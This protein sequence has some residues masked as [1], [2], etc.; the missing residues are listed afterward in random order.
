MEKTISISDELYQCFKIAAESSGLDENA[1]LND[2]IS[3]Y[4]LSALSNVFKGSTACR[5]NRSEKKVEVKES[6]NRSEDTLKKENDTPKN[7]SP[8]DVQQKLFVDW[9][10]TQT[11]DGKAYGKASIKQYASR[12][13]TTCRNPIFDRIPIKNLFEITSHKQFLSIQKRIK[14]CDG[15]A[16]FER[17]SSRGFSSAMQKY[18]EFLRY[19]EGK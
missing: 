16:E 19:Q 6:E 13:K 15:Y 9:F 10:Q 12:L 18:A 5:K 14:K 8:A 7:D 4:T 3:Q 17:K 11:H 1:L 2:L